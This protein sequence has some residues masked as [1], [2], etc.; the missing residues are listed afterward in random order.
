M[1]D[2]LFWIAGTWWHTCTLVNEYVYS[3]EN[4]LKTVTHMQIS[5]YLVNFTI[6]ELSVI[7]S[8]PILCITCIRRFLSNFFLRSN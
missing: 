7:Q 4:L 5:W 2:D 6:L 3:F 8:I 1:V